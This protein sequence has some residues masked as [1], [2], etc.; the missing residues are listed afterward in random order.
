MNNTETISLC[1]ISLL[2][3]TFI[4]QL[5]MWL[6]TNFHQNLPD[7]VHR[8]GCQW[9]LQGSYL[10]QVVQ[11][12]SLVH[13]RILSS[14]PYSA[15]PTIIESLLSRWGILGMQQT[16]QG[17]TK[18]YFY[19]NKLHNVQITL[20]FQTILYAK[21]YNYNTYPRISKHSGLWGNFEQD[22]QS[23]SKLIINLNLV[24]TTA[25]RLICTASRDN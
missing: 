5:D 17:K 8:H 19:N 6:A 10:P 16:V 18:Q 22:V 24:S 2:K 14:Q 9:H 11:W 20:R 21:A 1:S 13:Q 12:S 23:H 7:F 15:N 25:T 4:M 3:Q